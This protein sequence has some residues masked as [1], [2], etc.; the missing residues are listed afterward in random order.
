ME[1]KPNIVICT[2]QLS[3]R[4]GGEEQVVQIL[5]RLTFVW[6]GLMVV[7][8][9]YKRWTLGKPMRSLKDE[10]RRFRSKVP[11]DLRVDLESLTEISGFFEECPVLG[12]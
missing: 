1:V 5:G 2:E 11:D 3:N 12:E 9:L 10:I 4:C 8:C 7:V 6:C